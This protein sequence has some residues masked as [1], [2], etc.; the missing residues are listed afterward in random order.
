MEPPWELMYELFVS[1]YTE[2]EIEKMFDTSDAVAGDYSFQYTGN[3]E[4]GDSTIQCDR[5]DSSVTVEYFVEL[6]WMD[7]E[8][9]EVDEDELFFEF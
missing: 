1:G 2:S 4:T 9:I 3:V 5:Q 8:I 6:W 7:V